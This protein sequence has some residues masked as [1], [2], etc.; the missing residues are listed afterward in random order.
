MI[1]LKRKRRKGG[2]KRERIKNNNQFTWEGETYIPTG[3]PKQYKVQS[4][5]KII[6]GTEDLITYMDQSVKQIPNP[7]YVDDETT[8]NEPKYTVEQYQRGHLIYNPLFTNL[9]PK[10]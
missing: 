4:T 9:I 6:E 7:N 5:G 8:P 10:P 1:I 3:N 2:A